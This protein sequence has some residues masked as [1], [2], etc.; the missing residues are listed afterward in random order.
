MQTTAADTGERERLK[1][2]SCLLFIA[3]LWSLN[4]LFIKMVDWHPLAISSTR[5]AVAAVTL[6]L[7]Y[8]RLHLTWSFAQVGGAVAYAGAMITFV[9]ATKLTTSANA[10]LLQ[11][12]APVFIALLSYWFLK[13][14]V[15]KFD[16][17]IT[18]VVMGGMVLFFL[19]ELTAGSLLGN[20]LAI[21][22][23][24][25]FAC[26]NLFM[27]KQKEGSPVE[28]V[29]LGSILTALIGVPFFFTSG[30]P[31]GVYSWPAMSIMGVFMALSF[32]IYSNVIKQVRAIEAILVLIIEPMLNPLWV[33][34]ILG[35]RPGAWALLGGS[36]IVGSI[37][38]RGMAAT[39]RVPAKGY[40]V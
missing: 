11:Y 10:I 13:E 1:S 9:V 5:S 17:A 31:V 29:I 35:E 3:V 33:F 28:T 39:R 8:R 7:Y 2:I 37:V 34:L 15:T 32:I 23:G 40:P 26:F 22:S 14:R 19:D 30:L 6:L 18:A 20:L 25:T 4:G 21:L 24:V 36:I 27:R 38:L 16:W 12:T